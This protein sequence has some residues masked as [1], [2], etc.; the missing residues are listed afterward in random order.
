MTSERWPRNL[1]APSGSKFIWQPGGS[2][3]RLLF[4]LE[5]QNRSDQSQR[6]SVPSP[7]EAGL[8]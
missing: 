4:V 2:L 1:D 6:E 3:L 7:S 5:T 8:P